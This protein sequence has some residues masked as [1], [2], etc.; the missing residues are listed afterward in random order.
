VK[1]A[2]R[3]PDR[4]TLEEGM[5][6]W[7]KLARHS[8]VPEIIS[9]ADTIESLLQGILNHAD[10]PISS[11]KLEGTNNLIKTIHRKAY[12]FRDTEYFSLKIMEASRKPR[13][14]FQSHKKM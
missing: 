1:L 4:R 10:H 5:N 11:G 12:G 7:L 8:K 13:I 6:L 3:E 9:Y 2:F 14:R